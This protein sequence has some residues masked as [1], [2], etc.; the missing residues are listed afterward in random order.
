MITQVHL[1]RLLG[2]KVCDP[3]GKSAGRIEEVHAHKTQDGQC[4]IDEYMLGERAL[5]ERL[6]FTGAASV[7]V[8]QLG[9]RRR[10]LSYKVPWDKMDLSDPEYPKIRCRVDELEKAE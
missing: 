10:N 9:G 7:F 6:S 3:S 4:V 8:H 1:G 2:R 5:M